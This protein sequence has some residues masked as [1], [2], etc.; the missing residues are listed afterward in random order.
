VR[1]LDQA[2]A[3]RLAELLPVLVAEA[4]QTAEPLPT[5]RRLLRVL[6][7]IRARSAYFALL[8]H[9]GR[10]RARLVELAAHGDFL[11]DQIAAHPLLLD[12]LI[13][14][15]VF[16]DP[17]DRTAL[18]ADL[19]QRMAGADPQ[20]EEHLVE[21]LRHFQ[22]A[23]FFRLALADLLGHM[24]VM[25]VSDRLT[26]VAELI[27]ERALALAW[28]QLTPQLGVPMCEQNGQR[29]PVR[30]AVI[31]YGKLGG[32]ELGYG[33]DLDLVLVHDSSG[34]WQETVGARTIDNQVFFVRYAQRLLHLL[35]MHSAAGRLYEVD[36]RL[37]P[38]GKGG[39]L[40]TNI[41]A[42]AE[43][44]R[45]EAW[46]YEHQALLHA[47]AVAGAPELCARFEEL[48]LEMLA[49]HVRRANLREEVRAMRARMRRER[50]SS[51][52]DEFD[53]KQDAGG[54]A[55]IEFL[56]QYWALKWAAEYPP[57][58]RYADTIRQLESVASA[59]L[60]PQSKVDMLTHS[61]RA[62]R[63]ELHHRALAGLGAVVP[64]SAF[65]AERAAVSAL[66]DEVIG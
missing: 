30:I 29:R 38:S 37:R 25:K 13:D 34:A 10:V 27:L 2:G 6:E 24:P 1:R 3:R 7:A 63:Q 12:E 33:S 43:Y 41:D 15:R 56:A 51:S 20:D 59:D 18:E 28:Q 8:L 42:F 52:A 58:V 9:D 22:R 26:D 55:D 16:E 40:I 47:R 48:R 45:H 31:G 19:V 4:A 36:V 44:Q 65:R 61:Y 49:H 62:Y 23:A 14:A 21:R 39:M 17:P 57:V 5:L 64:A 50:S 54:I 66:W 60:V 35:T 32:M 11:I 53:L 46:T